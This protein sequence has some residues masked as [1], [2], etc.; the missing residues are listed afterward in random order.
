VDKVLESLRAARAEATANG[1]PLVVLCHSFGGEIVHDILTHYQP[2]FEIDVWITVG[3]QVGL[4][5]EMSLLLESKKRVGQAPGDPVVAP[6]SVKR[7]I[8]IADPNDIFGF[9]VMPVFTASAGRVVED[10]LYDTGYPVAGA[11]SGYF[12]WPSF[13]RR[14]ALRLQPK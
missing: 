6:A 2:G 10:Y 8:N 9:L 7:W 1:E 3:S 5:E 13:Y 14:L 12:E 11:H 4:F